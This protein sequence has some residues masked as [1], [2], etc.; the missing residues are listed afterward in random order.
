MRGL[1]D[2]RTTAGNACRAGLHRFVAPIPMGDDLSGFDVFARYPSQHRYL[3]LTR[4]GWDHEAGHHEWHEQDYPYCVRCTSRAREHLGIPP[5]LKDDRSS[6]THRTFGRQFRV[7]IR[8]IP[9]TYRLAHADN[10]D[11]GDRP[12]HP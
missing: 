3:I 11:R 10:D 6:T 12:A 7:R 4:M 1:G 8:A 9:A 2:I 5:R